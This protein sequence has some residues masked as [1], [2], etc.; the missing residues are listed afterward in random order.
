[1]SRNQSMQKYYLFKILIAGDAS[2]GKTSLLRRYV[3]G[4]FDES[5]IMTVGV[6]FFLKQI[7]FNSVGKCALQLWDLGGQERFRHLLEHYVMGA[8]AA[9]LLVDLTSMPKMDGILEWVNIVR[10]HDINLPIIL[11]GTKLDLGE[12]IVLDDETALNIKDTFHMIDYIK[13][14]SKTGTNV[15]EVFKLL[16]KK[17]MKID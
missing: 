13:T 1:M 8:R 16:G 14:S 3:D 6:E 9:L 15:D 12:A 5:T 4:M 7:E 17:L 11:V 10:M 2:V